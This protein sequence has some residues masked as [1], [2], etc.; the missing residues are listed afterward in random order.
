M[1]AAASAP[2]NVSLSRIAPPFVRW[3]PLWTLSRR[4]CG[5]I[6]EIRERRRQL[7][8]RTEAELLEDVAQVRLDRVRAQEELGRNFLVCESLGNEARDRQLLRRE[9]GPRR[10]D[11]T[12]RALTRRNQLSLRAVGPR[13]RPEVG[14]DIESLAHSLSRFE[15][16]L[17]AAQ[18]LAV[19]EERARAIERTR[20]EIVRRERS[21][22]LRVEAFVCQHRATAV[23]ERLGERTVDFPGLRLEACERR[24]RVGQPP[25]AHIG[26]DQG[27]KERLEFGRVDTA[28]LFEDARRR[29]ERGHCGLAVAEDELEMSERRVHDRISATHR[30]ELEPLG[31]VGA[32]A[33]LE[34]AQRLTLGDVTERVDSRPASTD[35]FRDRKLLFGGRERGEDAAG[36]GLDRVEVGEGGEQEWGR[37]DAGRGG[38]G[39]VEGGSGAAGRGGGRGRLAW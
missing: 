37:G 11:A 32:T 22:E 7:R 21:A 29:F 13:G 34:P 28:T 24:F 16:P 30:G 5:R 1:A 35:P 6:T 3:Q 14:E 15:P 25:R 26:L 12:A 36:E 39:L 4:R 18:A 33:L 19:T 23:S 27:W 10:G 8:A 20:V 2:M 9:L 17:R 38:E 31:D